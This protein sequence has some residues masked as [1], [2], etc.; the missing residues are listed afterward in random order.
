M[1]AFIFAVLLFIL[2]YPASAENMIIKEGNV[3]INAEVIAPIDMEQA[4]EHHCRAL[5]IDDQYLLDMFS[6][7]QPDDYEF[8]KNEN[9]TESHFYQSGDR[10]INSYIPYIYSYSTSMGRLLSG[11][12]YTSKYNP[13]DTTTMQSIMEFVSEINK[14][15]LNVCVDSFRMQTGDIVCK[16]MVEAE[17]DLAWEAE[18]SGDVWSDDRISGES[19]I[20][21]SRYAQMI[22]QIP[23]YQYLRDIPG[24]DSFTYDCSV[25]LYGIDDTIVYFR[26]GVFSDLVSSGEYGALI[27]SDKAA[28][29][30]C[31]EKNMMLGIDTV[32]CDGIRLEYMPFP[33]TGK[34]I[35][36]SWCLK[37]VWVFYDR[38][39]SEYRTPIGAVNALSGEYVDLW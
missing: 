19:L 25:E 35:Y 29:I 3:I 36:E 39:D 8:R 5:A 21:Y 11:Y 6:M 12:T 17:E 23:V 26:G 22:D 20:W 15:G 13:A 7:D 32:N 16:W 4:R 24:T 27:L 1:K 18:K 28:Q 30:F 14:T 2:C 31:Y 38:Y 33:E 10:M 34:L 37:P 9:G